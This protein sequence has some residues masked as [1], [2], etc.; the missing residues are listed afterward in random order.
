MDY[1]GE[2]V[3]L[4]IGAEISS[5]LD[6]EINS[7]R[8]NFSQH[9]WLSWTRPENLHVTI[10]FLGSVKIEMLENLISL[11]R[12]HYLTCQPAVLNSGRWDWAPTVTN[13]RMIWIRYPK[14]EAFSRLVISSRD[15]FSQIQATPQ[16]R[17]RPIPHITVARFRPEEKRPVN[18]PA[19]KINGALSITSLTL[20]RSEKSESGVKYIPLTTFKLGG[21]N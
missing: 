3:R 15:C 1:S 10:F 20:W 12:V 5:D 2:K 9:T 13:S 6:H 11:F 14:S 21:K 7:F 4:F 19:S 17:N 8:E 18:L 16:Q